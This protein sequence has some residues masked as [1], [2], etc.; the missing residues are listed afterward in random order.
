MNRAVQSVSAIAQ[1]V[2]RCVNLAHAR[3]EQAEHARR[4]NSRRHCFQA[5]D[6]HHRQTGTDRQP[7]RELLAYLAGRRAWS[8]RLGIGSFLT[9]E[10]GEATAPSTTRRGREVTHGEYH[11]WVYCSAWRIDLGSEILCGSEDDREHIETTIARLDGRTVVGAETSDAFEL[12]VRFDDTTTLRTFPIFSAGY[13]H[14]MV[15]APN[16]FVYT[17]GPGSTWSAEPQR[18]G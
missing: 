2:R 13:E 12:T 16:G 11:M 6:G 8:P 14:W 1:L 17:A 3:I 18:A 7:L 15:F 5:A 10:I 4:T 9:L